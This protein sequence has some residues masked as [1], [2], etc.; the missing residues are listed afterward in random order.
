M[1]ITIAIDDVCPKPGYRIVQE[2]TGEWLHQLNEEFG[3]KFTLFIPSNYHGE[4]PISRY[5]SWIDCLLTTSYFE[6]AAHGHF[7]ITSDRLKYGECEFINLNEGDTKRRLDDLFIEWMAVQY[8]PKG[9]RSPG[10][11]TSPEAAKVIG[12]NFYYIAAHSEHNLGIDWGTEP[13]VF[14]GHDGIHQNNIGI[15]NGD[16]IMF[17]SHIAGKHNHNVWS[18]DNFLQLRESLRFLTENYECEFKTLDECV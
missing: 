11:L 15:H 16:M 13:C 17:Q 1:R 7:H 3:A 10:W 18:E 8:L 14:Y 12:R 4:Y 5:L 2:Q 6:L 9:W